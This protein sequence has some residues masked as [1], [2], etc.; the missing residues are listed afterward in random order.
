MSFLPD[1]WSFF[2]QN[3][4]H[5]IEPKNRLE[6]EVGTACHRL[7]KAAD[8]RGREHPDVRAVAV[9]RPGPDSAPR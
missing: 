4:R 1:F 5:Q 3:W 6:V 2:L 7:A 9:D 8:R